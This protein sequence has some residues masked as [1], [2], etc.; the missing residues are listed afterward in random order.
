MRAHP[1]LLLALVALAGLACD[2]KSSSELQTKDIKATIEVRVDADPTGPHTEMITFLARDLEDVVLAPGDVLEGRTDKDPAQPFAKNDLNFY[3]LVLPQAT[4][5]TEAFV[6]LTRK[7]GTSAPASTVKI[8]PAVALTA[9]AAG[10]QWSYATGKLRLEWSNPVP[11]ANVSVFPSPCGGAAASTQ[12]RTVDDK[13]SYE[14]AASEVLVGMPAPQGSCVRLRISRGL[15]GTIDP[16]FAPKSR[17]DS[18][19]R[20]YVDVTVVP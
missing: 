14:L 12:V 4:S 1:R 5:G 11:G 10:S 7:Q 13:G 8:A 6:T 18:F 17:I 15:A 2:P 9:P 3:K 16:A 20:D 19:R